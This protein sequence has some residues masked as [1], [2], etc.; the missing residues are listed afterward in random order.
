MA[1]QAEAQGTHIDRRCI[2]GQ[3]P[4]VSVSK[5]RKVSSRSPHWSCRLGPALFRE[6]LCFKTTRCSNCTAIAGGKCDLRPQPVLSDSPA[7]RWLTKRLSHVQAIRHLITRRR[8]ISA[9]L[10]YSLGGPQI[11]HGAPATCLGQNAS[12]VWRQDERHDQRGKS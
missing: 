5:A 9:P 7:R 8:A 2:I 3:E 12:H 6:R 11:Q 10:Y 4:V 1:V